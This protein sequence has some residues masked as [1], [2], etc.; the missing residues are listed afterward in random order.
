M[1]T[2]ITGTIENSSDQSIR[3]KI[4]EYIDPHTSQKMYR[5]WDGM[6]YRLLPSIPKSREEVEQNLIKAFSSD[7]MKDVFYHLLK[8]GKVPQL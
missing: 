5:V 8:L 3:K 2:S 7:S 4:T 1:Q 6:A